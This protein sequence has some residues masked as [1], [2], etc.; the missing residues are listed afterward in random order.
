MRRRWGVFG[1]VLCAFAVAG[2][3]PDA[4]ADD[5]SPN[6][7]NAPAAPSLP[8]AFPA[9]PR[10]DES[11]LEPSPGGFRVQS[12][13][14]RVSAY[15][16]YGYGYQ[17]QAG[18]TLGAGSERATIF[19]SQAEIVATA[20]RFI[21]RLWVPV[22]VVTAASPD[23]IDHTPASADVVS[24]ASRKV[25]S[26]TIDWTATYLIDRAT[27][28]SLRNAVHLE[29]PLRSWN[30][31][32]AARRSFADDN[33]VVAGNLVAV[34]DW[35]DNFDI[36][37]HRHGHD[38]RSGTA[39]SVSITQILTPTTVAN[40]NYGLTLQLGTLGNTWNSVP[41]I[42]GKRGPE[43]LP[44]DRVRHALVGRFAQFLPW[45]GALRGYYRFYADDWG[46]VAH[47]VEAQL[48]QRVAPIAYVGALYR[49]H[50]QTGASF[51]TT[52]GSDDA[53]YRVADSDLAPL[54]SHTLGGK[55][56]VDVPWV[57]AF[58]YEE[59]RA[60]HFEVGYER[61]VRSNDLQMNIV[62]WATGFRF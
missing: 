32:L 50:T 13:T 41:L 38:K 27:D 55:V 40:I 3:T 17:S 25:I 58:G 45:N 7:P 26:G 24:S 36:T 43:L 18:P 51:F 15:D 12:I 44:T 35:F 9:A 2:A 33:T 60:L 49:F 52:L 34:F 20:G 61:Y 4:R 11:I 5:A 16:Q 47:S 29:E 37:G 30:S 56:V 6:A 1:W 46:I 54:D 31:S 23:S 62:T 8:S 39:G 48:M 28:V 22:D 19:E 14:T 53:T 21:H 10:L 59:V 42:S 57:A